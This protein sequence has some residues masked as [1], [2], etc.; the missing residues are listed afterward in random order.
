MSV[1]ALAS[2]QDTVVIYKVL[3]FTGVGS[4]TL[5]GTKF[6]L[7]LFLKNEFFMQTLIHNSAYMS[8]QSIDMT[9]LRYGSMLYYEIQFR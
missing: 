3:A 5:L 1:M 4:G 7:L 6:S 2:V 8:A 9:Y